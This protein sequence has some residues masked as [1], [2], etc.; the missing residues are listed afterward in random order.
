MFGSIPIFGNSTNK[1]D[2][3][4]RIFVPKFTDAEKGDQL[5]I[6][7]SDVGNYYIICN[8]TKIHQEIERLKDDKTAIELLTSSIVDLV[9]V[10]SQRR[11][12]FRQWENFAI[13]G[14]IFI[15]GNYDSL[16][17]FPSEEDYN[18]HIET[19]KKSH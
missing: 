14:K 17:V 8:C 16:Q 19:L 11:I 12:N 18:K 1:I 15:H 7:K 4:G 9:K 10:D 3:K 5:V 6:Q 2:N 13:D